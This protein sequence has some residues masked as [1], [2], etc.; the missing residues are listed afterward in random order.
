M[1]W[2]SPS[3]VSK[4]NR[5]VISKA[6]P[7]ILSIPC[8]WLAGSFCREGFA[9]VSLPVIALLL[10]GC[11]LQSRNF[12][13]LSLVL[14]GSCKYANPHCT[15]RV[16][17]FISCT[18]E[19]RLDSNLK[20]HQ[21]GTEEGRMKIKFVLLAKA[22]RPA[23]R[24]W[25]LICWF[26]C[27]WEPVAPKGWGMRFFFREPETHTF[28]GLGE[29]LHFDFMQQKQPNLSYN[30]SLNLK[31]ECFPFFTSKNNSWQHQPVDLGSI[32]SL[33]IYHLLCYCVKMS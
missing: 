12:R 16:D 5:R 6:F 26:Q 13:P 27:F 32:Y 8:I 31:F 17:L 7:S 10:P 9:L 29:L 11:T 22:C 1:Q 3:H 2:W 14:C 23:H 28:P 21:K 25:F 30:S 33:G 24:M 18:D 15:I 20:M 4:A 19:N